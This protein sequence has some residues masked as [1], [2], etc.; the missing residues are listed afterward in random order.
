[1]TRST[2]RSR[3]IVLVAALA[4][5][6]AAPCDAASATIFAWSDLHGKVPSGLKVLVDS[7][8]AA[9][10]SNGRSVF[11]FDGG[12]ALFG[13]PLSQITRG[14]AQTAELNFLKPDA[15]TLG[16]GDFAWDRSRLDS[17]LMVLDF[18]V[19]TANLRRNVD[20]A[21]IGNGRGKLLDT[22][23]IK[24]GVVGVADP[25]LDY[26]N[27]PERN[28]DMRVDPEDAAVASE[29][30]ALRKSGATL[31]V[32]LCNTSESVAKKLGQIDGV[33]LVLN[34][35][36]HKAGS[37][38]RDGDTWTAKL[39]SGGESVLRIDLERGEG[40]AWTA[41]ATTIPVPK[42][43]P[44]NAAWKAMDA[45]HDSLVKALFSREVGNLKAPWPTTRREGLL[46]NWMADALRGGTG[47]DIGLVPASWIRKGLPKGRVRVEDI[48]NAVPPGLN[49]VSVFTLPGSDVMKFLERQMRRS[50]EFLFISGLTCTPD[51]S[52]FGGSPISASIGGKLLDKSAYYKIAIPLQLRNDIYE[53]TGISESSAGAEWTRIWES[54]MVVQWALDKGLSTELGRVPAM[55]GGTAPK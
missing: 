55:Y 5:M 49:M 15:M 11:A 50:K 3:T 44:T 53:L 30:A 43:R 54:D 45:S 24:L 41:T 8:R 4:A 39:P 29:V 14:V 48:W 37:L 36:D 28:G 38:G 25:E 27:R 17:L 33:D 23:G 52:M 7:A 6:A 40:G 22:A 19:L 2:C 1:M 9:G 32:V 21:P 20:D 42:A 26:P 16:L 51:S 12:D 13:S 10:A 31:V 18:P 47:A 46:G 34:S 35:H